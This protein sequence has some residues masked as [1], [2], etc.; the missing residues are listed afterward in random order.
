[1]INGRETRVL[2][3][4]MTSFGEVLEEILLSAAFIRS[5]TMEDDR[6]ADNPWL[7]ENA[8]TTSASEDDDTVWLFS[9][10][11]RARLSTSS[12]SSFS[13]V[14]GILSLLSTDKHYLAIS[15]DF[16]L[17]FDIGSSWMG[18]YFR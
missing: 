1:M 11:R 5:E 14:K 10:S 3:E 17:L 6:R 16:P 18:L 9:A 8:A 2:P 15:G 13:S 12:G 4:L 7:E